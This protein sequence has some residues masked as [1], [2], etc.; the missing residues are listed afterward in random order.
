MKCFHEENKSRRKGF[1]FF[2]YR[3]LSYQKLKRGGHLIPGGGAYSIF[4]RQKLKELRKID[5]GATM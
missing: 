1:K 5:P 2:I 4:L 3:I